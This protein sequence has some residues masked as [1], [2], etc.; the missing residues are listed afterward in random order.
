MTRGGYGRVCGPKGGVPRPPCLGHVRGGPRT[1]INATIISVSNTRISSTVCMTG[2]SDRSACW[3][4]CT[5]SHIVCRNQSCGTWNPPDTSLTFNACSQDF[6]SRRLVLWNE[7][8][9]LDRIVWSRCRFR[10][11]LYNTQFHSRG[12][13][14]DN[15]KDEE[16]FWNRWRGSDSD[17]AGQSGASSN[18]PGCQS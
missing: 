8:L 4:L 10:R 13:A 6:F 11:R 18:W 15:P 16:A 14:R 17:K 3:G 7:R 5:D 1:G 9:F 12:Y 2:Q